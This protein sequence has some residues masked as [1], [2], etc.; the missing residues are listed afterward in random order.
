M[1]INKNKQIATD[2]VNIGAVLLGIIQ[3]NCHMIIMDR[4]MILSAVGTDKGHRKPRPSK[5]AERSFGTV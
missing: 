2:I 3:S 1:A 4:A 5:Q